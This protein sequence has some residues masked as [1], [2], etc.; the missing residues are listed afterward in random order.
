MRIYSSKRV[1]LRER[2]TFSWDTKQRKTRRFWATTFTIWMCNKTS[3]GHSL[4][5]KKKAIRTNPWANQGPSH[6][7]PAS[8]GTTFL[9]WIIFRIKIGRRKGLAVKLSK[10][11]TALINGLSVWSLQAVQS[12]LSREVHPLKM[13]FL[14]NATRR[15]RNRWTTSLPRWKH[16]RVCSRKRSY[17]R[18]CHMRKA[19]TY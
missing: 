14:E 18:D 10:M 7:C 1:L 13:L 3:N 4:P 9:G 6:R 16:S 8:L 5:L 11:R 17:P 19:N 12:R 15:S 2:T